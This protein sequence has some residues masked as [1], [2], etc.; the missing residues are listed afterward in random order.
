MI[1]KK[2]IA[3]EKIKEWYTTFRISAFALIRALTRIRDPS[4]SKNKKQ[5]PSLKKRP[6]PLPLTF[7]NI[8][9]IS[10]WKSTIGLN[11]N[12]YFSKWGTFIKGDTALLSSLGYI[13]LLWKCPSPLIDWALEVAVQF[14][15]I[16][17][18]AHF[19]FSCLLVT[20]SLFLNVTWDFLPI[21]ACGNTA[22]LD[23]SGKKL[24]RSDYSQIENKASH[25]LGTQDLSKYSK[26]LP[27]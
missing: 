24:T 10:H 8:V 20:T 19:L 4:L 26:L 6:L 12:P 5:A 21:S 25:S 23:T 16:P 1:N 2:L 14:E 9:R 13:P 15:S 17:A 7:L 3:D 11:N 27:A 18:S 22:K